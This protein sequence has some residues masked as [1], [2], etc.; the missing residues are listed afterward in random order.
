MN[1][2]IM[3]PAPERKRPQTAAKALAVQILTLQ[4]QLIALLT[5]ETKVRVA[6][7]IEEADIGT[8]VLTPEE[9]EELAGIGALLGL[10]A[11]EGSWEKVAATVKSVYIAGIRRGIER[12][13][14]VQEETSDAV[15]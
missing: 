1:N 13:T 4:N 9:V 12:A 10:S 6:A 15:A 3:N 7:L 11:F 2:Q 14:P 5:H 8:Y